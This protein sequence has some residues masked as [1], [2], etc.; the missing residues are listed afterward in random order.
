MPSTRL[1]ARSTIC[2]AMSRPATA[3]V[4]AG[5]DAEASTRGHYRA[6]LAF[7]GGGG[8]IVYL[9]GAAPGDPG[10][11]TRR[12]LELIASADAVL[13]DRLIPAGALDGA[14]PDARLV[15]V[16]KQPGGHTMRQEEINEL[17]VQ[18]GGE[19]PVV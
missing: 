9:V 5:P 15:Y 11:M 2:P 17:L 18:L 6:S 19:L 7:P 4:A 10:L 8:G 13:Y 12:A 16:G 1:S 14:R 3:R